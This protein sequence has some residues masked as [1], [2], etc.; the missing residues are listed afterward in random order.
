MANTATQIETGTS[1]YGRD[2]EKIGEVAGTADSYFIIEKGFIF[3]TDV[4]V[5][6]SAVSG[7]DGDGVRLSL[8]KQEVENEDWSSMPTETQASMT[9]QDTLERSE[10]RLTVDT[11]TQQAGTARVGKHVEEARQSVDVPLTR[12]EVDVERRAVD[13]TADGDAFRD[14][15]LEVPVYE[16]R[17]ETG[18]EARVVDELEIDKNPVTETRR[19]ED[20]VRREEFDVDT[21]GGRR[22]C[23]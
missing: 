15:S 19:V 4:Y 18:K 7:V 3:T 20:T 1:V 10:E 5:P 12:E 6:M 22:T 17:V 16:E 11:Q 9:D 8:T 13:R 23:R 2:G 14:E 21:E